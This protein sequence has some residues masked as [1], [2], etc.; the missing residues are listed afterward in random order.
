MRTVGKLRICALGLF[1][2][3]LAAGATPSSAAAAPEAG[4]AWHITQFSFP[5]TLVPG[6]S[7]S[8]SPSAVASL[9]QYST[10]ITNVGSVPTTEPIVVTETLPAE[11]ASALSQPP[12]FVIPGHDGQP[13]QS[14]GQ[15]VTCEITAPISPGWSIIVAV[16]L[17]VSA[18]ASTPVLSQVEV[19]GGG[20]A[21]VTR[22]LTTPVGTSIPAFGFL[23]GSRGIAGRATAES[24]LDATLA[25]SHPFSFIVEANFPARKGG[26][27]VVPVE[28]PRNISFE[29]PP[30]VVVNPQGP[31]VLCTEAQL[32]TR[33]QGEGIGGCPPGSQVGFIEIET[34]IVG[35]R[36]LGLSLYQMQPPP[37]VAAELGFSLLGTI[38]HIQGGVDGDFH[39]TAT[40]NDI[41]AK[42]PVLG[43][44][45]YLWGNPADPRHDRERI[46]AGCP[47][48]T[49]CSIEPTVPFVAM[50]TACHGPLDLGVTAASWQGT[51]ATADSSFIDSEGNP[52]EISGCNALEFEPTISSKATTNLAD[53]PSGLDFNLHQPQNQQLDGFATAALKDVRV[54]LPEGM[55]L[56]ASAGN[57]LDSCTESQIGYAPTE[58]KIRFATTPQTCPNAAKVGTLEVTTPLLG[59]KLPGAV[60][61]A[62]PYENPFGSL[63]AIYLAVEDEESGVIAKLA[64]KVT[65]D[66]VTGQLTANFTESPQLPLED[67]D[68]RFFN[69]AGAALTT[70]LTC[71][72]KTTTSTLTPWST[73]EGADASPTDSFQT[74]IAAGG[75]GNCP[76]SEANAPNAPAFT[77]GTV[78][79]EAGAYSPFVLKLS[80][81]D[82]TQRLT[83][84][85]TT[86]PKGLAAKFA[87]IPY[88]SEPQI[89][90]AQAR[91]NPNQGALEQSNPSCPS[92][93]EVGT[94]EV[95]AG[96]GPTPLYVQGHAYL[97]GPYK[98]APLSLAIVT[99]AVAGP[100]DL[101]AVVV[102][103]AL[104][105]DP[106]TAQG[107]AVSDPL[108]SILQGIPLDIRSVAI[109]LDRPGGFTLNPTSCDPMA[110]TGS[111]MALTGQSA[112]LTSP[113]QVG[114]CGALKFKPNLKIS[115]K[116][117]TKRHR[118]PALKAVLT[119]PKGA[120]ANIASAQVT[121]PHSAFLEQGHIGTVCTRVQFAAN[122]CPRAS[123]YGKAKAITPLLDQ[124]LEGP[125]YLRSS[126]HEL[127]DLVAALNGQIDVDLVGRVDTGKGG[128]I[129]NTF[130]AAPDAPVSK[131]VLEMKGG[132]K[133]LLVNS[134]N[135]CRKTQKASVSFTAQNGAALA[136]TPTIKNSCGGKAKKKHAKKG[137]SH[138]KKGGRGK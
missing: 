9:P 103:T 70:P 76:T 137:G 117:G 110:V 1:V 122:A 8:A 64:G 2:G 93:S 45:A 116:G 72:T 28:A 48:T 98:G 20:L 112:A 47:S 80:R 55:T 15:T 104:Y 60:Y 123:I 59:H 124:P 75:S 57:G 34:Q 69:G 25:G 71:G 109:K 42:V 105:V 38:V 37:G 132:K 82:G 27:G 50:P 56:N 39:L 131:F 18:S 89:A 90:Q 92:A 102:R 16:P 94:V 136:L 121:L 115:L 88:C 53:S 133:G 78:S 22:T 66:P 63:L 7:A 86:L 5:T 6:S 130:E 23:P 33:T 113:F 118:F 17:D 61:L 95:G 106:E 62:K 85:D 138:G 96:S 128:G 54:T 14:S 13:C 46:G 125:V 29:L 91:S 74:Q 120:N 51:S 97:A 58:G 83:A 126:S 35:V 11:V 31:P 100:F 40:S 3:L 24:G 127:P 4:P 52:L 87:G 108:P 12:E 41:L 111:A 67:I 135:I 73:P 99:P 129:R 44:R 43:V 119:Y 114:G 65:P 21:A 107:H 32:L 77:A 49:G 19:S 26:P 10:L 79:P 101:G 36:P 134:E 68:L 81:P 30:G 84:I